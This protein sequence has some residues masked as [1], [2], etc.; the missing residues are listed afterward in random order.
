MDC[1]RSNY[2]MS[3]NMNCGTNNYSMNT[4]MR[5]NYSSNGDVRINSYV[6]M[7]RDRKNCSCQMED[8]DSGCNIVKDHIDHMC[9]AMAYVP[10]QKWECVYDMTKGFERGTIFEQLDKPYVGRCEK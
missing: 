1:N 10:W 2:N 9:P 5:R 6:K 4:G 3:H 7:N 8:D